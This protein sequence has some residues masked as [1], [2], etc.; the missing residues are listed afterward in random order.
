MYARLINPHYGPQRALSWARRIMS[1][2]SSAEAASVSRS[3]S[4]SHSAKWPSLFAAPFTSQVSSPL[5]TPAVDL[6]DDERWIGEDGG[7]GGG[8]STCLPI[9]QAKMIMKMKNGVSPVF[10]SCGRAHCYETVRSSYC[11]PAYPLPYGVRKPRPRL[12]IQVFTVAMSWN[13]LKF[14]KLVFNMR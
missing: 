9:S 13:G 3:I 6:G 5:S 14:C 7:V 2:S 1:L 12:K 4:F 10:A 11:R 8:H